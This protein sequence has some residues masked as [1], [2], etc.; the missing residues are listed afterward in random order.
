MS[1]K[2]DEEKM[3]PIAECFSIRLKEVMRQNEVSQTALA[4]I[5][6]VQPATISRYTLGIRI[7][8]VVVVVQ[9][10]DYF[11]VSVDYLLGISDVKYIEE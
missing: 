11:N 5:L 10:A 6:N 9:I 2:I 8:T 3:K 7:P 4:K 1:L